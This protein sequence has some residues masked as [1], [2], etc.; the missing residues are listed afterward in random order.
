MVSKVKLHVQLDQL[1]E[2]LRQRMVPHLE[3][4][5]IGQNDLI[6]CVTD[7]NPSPQQKSR[8]NAETELLVQMGRKILALNEKLDES[9]EGS[10]ADRLCWYCRKWGRKTDSDG[11]TAQGLA[12]DFLQEINNTKTRT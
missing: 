3:K 7:F 4:A 5:A 12:R 6:F 8:A 9:S 2:E 1:E 10:I 11:K